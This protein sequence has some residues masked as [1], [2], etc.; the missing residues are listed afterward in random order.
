MVLP[1]G[2][3]MHM[4]GS[5]FS[6]VLKIAFVLGVFGQDLGM[7]ML[8]PVVLVAVL[9]SVGTSGVPGGGY[10]G[11]YIICSISSLSRLPIRSPFWLPSVIWWIPLPP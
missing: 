5:C 6:C 7:N 3:T 8:I 9:S 2:A 11:E 1:L 4:D 10:I